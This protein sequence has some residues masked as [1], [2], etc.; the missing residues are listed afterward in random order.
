MPS[1]GGLRVH[2]IA[3]G[4]ESPLT[5]HADAQR[6][7]DTESARYV[8]ASLGKEFKIVITPSQALLGMLI[9]LT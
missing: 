7:R 6:H 5:E 2:I 4:E 3:D 1:F 9:V 8:Y